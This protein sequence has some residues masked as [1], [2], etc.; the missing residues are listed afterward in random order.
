MLAFAQGELGSAERAH[1]LAHVDECESCRIVAAELARDNA[2]GSSSEP[3]RPGPGDVVNGRYRL[4]ATLGRGAMGTVFRAHDE[5][6]ATDVA[7]KM[8]RPGHGPRDRKAFAREVTVGRKITHRNVCRLHDAASTDDVDYITMELVDGESLAHVLAR[9]ELPRGRAL[10]VLSEIAAGLAAAH[11]AGIVH[12]DL[13]PA[14]VMIERATGRAVLTDFGF[15][16]DLDAKQSRRL[17]GTPAYWSP[18]QARGEAAT[19]ASD[20]YS[21]GV[22]AYRLLAHT[23]FSLS[24][25]NALAH[26]PRDLRRAVAKCLE[27]RPSD[28]FPDAAAAGAAFDQATRRRR[29]WAA[30]AIVLTAVAAVFVA[31]RARGPLAPKAPAAEVDRAAARAPMVMAPPTATPTATAPPETTSVTADLVASAA[32]PSESAPPRATA[33]TH[34]HPTVGRVTA[35]P[36]PAASATPTSAASA[37]LTPPPPSST[38]GDLLYRK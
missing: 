37:A 22:L 6:L 10:V 32:P 27:L 5:E 25:R 31:A 36:P 2:S 13:K 38:D 17:V 20:V 16:T 11:A 34:V 7:L 33:A 29:T 24:D 3:R 12:R 8:L 1:A 18:E 14:N 23:E 35:A 26:V 19:K 9:E 4:G 15:A 21:F 30:P 28:R